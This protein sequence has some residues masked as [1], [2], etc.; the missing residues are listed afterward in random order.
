MWH[1]EKHSQLKQSAITILLPRRW[2]K[3]LVFLKTCSCFDPLSCL[4]LLH[5]APLIHGEWTISEN[6][7]ET[8]T[9]TL[10]SSSTDAALSS[11]YVRIH[12]HVGACSVFSLYEPYFLLLPPSMPLFANGRVFPPLPSW[13]THSRSD[14]PPRSLRGLCAFSSLSAKIEERSGRRTSFLLFSSCVVV[15]QPRCRA[16]E[17]RSGWRT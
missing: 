2:E 6:W 10:P 1:F 8:S 9:T 11:P 7:K 5:V 12:T 14:P 4:T 3:L 16:S 17:V 13:W 15:D